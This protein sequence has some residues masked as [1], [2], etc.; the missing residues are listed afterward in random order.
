[1]F[2]EPTNTVFWAILACEFLAAFSL[3]TYLAQ[4]QKRGNKP[5]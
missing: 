5:Q 3:I 1:M 4:G 2:Q